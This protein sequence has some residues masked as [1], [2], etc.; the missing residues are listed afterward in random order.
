MNIIFLIAIVVA[1]ILGFEF[2]KHHF[3]KSSGKSVLTL[4]VFIIIL[5]LIFKY[6]GFDVDASNIATTGA[7]IVDDVKDGL[8]DFDLDFG[9]DSLHTRKVYIASTELII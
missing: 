6:S 5:F 9:L 3:I 1:I 4:I 7:S 2:I 8:D